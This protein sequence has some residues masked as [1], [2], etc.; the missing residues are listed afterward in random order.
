MSPNYQ[1]QCQCGNQFEKIM[2][3]ALRHEAH[4]PDCGRLAMKKLSA[5][6][7]SFGWHFT[8]ESHLVG[9]RHKD[10]LEPNI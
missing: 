8:P 5:F 10:G 4:C 6:N 3:I 2:P 7:F 1:Y 9:A